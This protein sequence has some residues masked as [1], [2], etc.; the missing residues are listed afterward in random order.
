MNKNVI[1]REMTKDD[2]QNIIKWRNAPSVVENFIYRT[3][4]DEEAHLNWY[5]NRVKTGEVAQFI[6]V[7]KESNIDV[8]SV[9]LRDIDNKNRKC[10]YGIFIGEESCRGKG[11]G[12][13]AA[14]LVLDYA[15]KTLNMNRVFLR[16]FADNPRAIRSYEKA[17]F[18]YE[19]TFKADVIIDSVPRDMV[20][21]AILK[22]D[23]EK[24]V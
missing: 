22:E 9:Y 16:V 3:P 10:E 17:G 6:I 8:G 4:L 1:L 21:M 15:F 2:T 12:S 5:N 11:I 18:K 24:G 13:A 23:W 20:F 19:G 7:D 14:K